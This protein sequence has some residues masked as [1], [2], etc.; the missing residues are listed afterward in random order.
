MKASDII[1]ILE[2]LAPPHLAESW[3]NCGL[4]I[5]SKSREIIKVYI[6]LDADSKAIA[7]AVENGCDMIITHHP[8]LFSPV[9]AVRDDDFTGKRLITLI[10][11]RVNCY[12]MHTNFDSAVMGDLCAGYLNIS[13]S[14]PLEP[15]E[16]GHGIGSIGMLDEPMKLYDLAERVKKTFDLPEARYYGDPD[17]I[18]SRIAMCPGSGKGFMDAVE[19]SHADVYLTGDVDHHFALDL[20]EKGI[21]VID[22][23]HH[24]LEHVFVDYM[25]DYLGRMLPELVC[26]ADKNLS[27]FGIV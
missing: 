14:T 23:G 18:V 25:T 11:N 27:P 22:A 1:S 8:I 26:I 19:D 10:E 9:R 7:S 15:A 12:A 20:M 4:L 24:G 21:S 3:D 16:D 2:Q 13:G 6:A 17:R 5:G